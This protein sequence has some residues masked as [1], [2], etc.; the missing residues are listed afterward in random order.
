MSPDTDRITVPTN[1]QR[2]HP[3]PQPADLTPVDDERP[4]APAATAPFTPTQLAVGFGILAALIA[5][6]FRSLRRRSRA[7]RR[8]PFGRR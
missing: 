1:G 3:L 4:A 5:L 2:P 6:A 7:G 8:G